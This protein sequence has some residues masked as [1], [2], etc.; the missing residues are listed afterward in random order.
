PRSRWVSGGEPDAAEAV[1][2]GPA[3]WRISEG[4]GKAWVSVDG[5]GVVTSVFM[6][7]HDQLHARGMTGDH[8]GDEGAVLGAASV[9]L[10]KTSGVGHVVGDDDEPRAF[11]DARDLLFKFGSEPP[12]Q[13]VIAPIG[14]GVE[15]LGAA[16]IGKPT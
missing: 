14:L 6:A 1:R 3:L 10:R 7:V 5:T 9:P 11:L 8:L 13:R 2:R 15:P 12:R 4:V 16:W